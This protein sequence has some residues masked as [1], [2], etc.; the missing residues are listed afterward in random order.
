MKDIS[1]Y[2]SFKQPNKSNVETD[3][4]PAQAVPEFHTQFIPENASE[5]QMDMK[6]E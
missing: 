6:V 5:S 2:S 3:C 1:E 4:L